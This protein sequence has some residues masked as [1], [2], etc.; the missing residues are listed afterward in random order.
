MTVEGHSDPMG[1][2]QAKQKGESSQILAQIEQAGKNLSLDRA[3]AV[4]SSFLGYAKKNGV[5]LAGDDFIA[6][7]MGIRTPKFKEPKSKDEWLGNMRVTFRIK[8]IEAELS[9]FQPLK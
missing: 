2:A 3:N 5:N 1:L 9:E 7:G 6:V 4:K 8:Q